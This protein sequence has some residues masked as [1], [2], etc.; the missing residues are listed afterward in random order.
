MAKGQHGKPPQNQS[1]GVSGVLLIVA[2]AVAAA[3]F[4]GAAHGLNGLLNV[5]PGTW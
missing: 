4:V 2:L 1:A 5:L 3:S